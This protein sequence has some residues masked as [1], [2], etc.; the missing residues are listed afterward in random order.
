MQTGVVPTKASLMKTK[1]LL[2]FSEKGFELLDKKRNVL[3]TEMMGLM[4][5]ARDIQNAIST[6]FGKAYEALQVVNISLGVFNVEEIAVSIPILEEFEI[7]MSSIMGA[8]I[9]TIKY[10]ESRIETYYGF[11]RTNPALDIALISFKQVKYLVY[12]LAEVE[13]SVYK[14]AMEIKKTQKRANALEK[15]QIPRYK[16]QLKTIREVL[17]EKE[18]EEFFRIKLVKQ[19]KQS[20]INLPMGRQHNQRMP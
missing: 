10:E 19:R 8:E 4:D 20:D 9:P 2:E 13:N 11:F 7:L 5:R 12:Q 1:S 18:R 17:E 16:K 14:L 3:I 6:T 15:I